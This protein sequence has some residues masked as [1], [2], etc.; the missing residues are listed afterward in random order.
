MPGC[1]C[2]VSFLISFICLFSVFFSSSD[3]QVH[4]C[5][6][7]LV[8]FLEF[9]DRLQPRAEMIQEIKKKKLTNLPLRQ[10]VLHT[11]KVNRCWTFCGWKTFQT[12]CFTM[13]CCN[14]RHSWHYGGFEPEDS[15][16]EAPA[17]KISQGGGFTMF[18]TQNFSLQKSCNFKVKRNSP[19]KRAWLEYDRLLIDG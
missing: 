10:E 15:G 3:S 14:Q 16:R 13:Q 12:I 18:S 1:C 5:R 19:E 17:E 7:V 9:S 11:S 6:P 8:T 2:L 4:G